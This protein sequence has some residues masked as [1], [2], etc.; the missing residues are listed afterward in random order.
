M[1]PKSEL[2]RQRENIEKRYLLLRSKK[3]P[4]SGFVEDTLPYPGR[5]GEVV[6]RKA[7]ALK[8]EWSAEH[9][10]Q[11]LTER[12]KED[13]ENCQ[14][15]VIPPRDPNNNNKDFSEAMLNDLKQNPLGRYP[16]A[17]LERQPYHDDTGDSGR[18]VVGRKK[19]KTVY[20]VASIVDDHDVADVQ[21]VASQYKLYGE[22]VE[23][24]LVSP[25]IKGERDD[26]S[27]EIIKGKKKKEHT[28]KIVSILSTMQSLSPF[29]NNI[30]TYETHSSATQA[31]AAMFGM[32]LIPFSL[33]EE[34]I[35]PIKNKILDHREWRLVRP[36]VGRTMIAKRLSEI[37]DMKGVSL[38]KFR[39]GD[40][41][42][43]SE[44][45]PLTPQEIRLLK[46]K[47][48]LLYDDEGATLGTVKDVTLNHLLKA[49]V[50]SVNILLGHA[51]L[52]KGWN[53][54]LKKMIE[55]CNAKKIPLKI[56]ITDSRVPIG[57]LNSLIE[58]Y[59]DNI[60]LV[61]VADKTRR[62]IEASINGV[63]FF[64][65]NNWGG[66]DWERLILQSIPGYDFKSNNHNE[67]R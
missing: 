36:D 51:R 37:L 66:T 62:V 8:R 64:H 45:K 59:P 28:G 12:S 47:N 4:L 22:D 2:A 42:L 52:Q 21:H 25:F 32:D 24:N 50:K 34:L 10:R 13:R 41:D 60:E 27:V 26:K 39:K 44:D 7:L 14:V 57:D 33:Y 11:K 23:V 58:D 49:G 9:W 16:V 40:D 61:S 43:G 19:V 29:V 6:F 55:A 46:G 56:Y 53:K 65:D 30:F 67:K 54:N 48:A 35:A 17:H 5:N 38:S 3:V 20:I 15:V 31:F 63:D 18:K 1:S